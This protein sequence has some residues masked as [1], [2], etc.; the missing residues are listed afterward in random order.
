MLVVAKIFM[1]RLS[2]LIFWSSLLLEILSV[3][4][5]NTFPEK[6]TFVVYFA[7]C[8]VA[9]GGLC[10]CFLNQNSSGLG[11]FINVYLG[12]QAQQTEGCFLMWDTAGLPQFWG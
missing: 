4:K 3:F 12:E 6:Y 7:F 2:S 1:N 10:T 9:R 11:W 8:H 5:I